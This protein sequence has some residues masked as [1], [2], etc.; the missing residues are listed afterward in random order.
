MGQNYLR[1]GGG[2]EARKQN[3]EIE[4]TLESQKI[5]VIYFLNPYY[6]VTFDDLFVN[7]WGEVKGEIRDPLK[8]KP[9]VVFTLENPKSCLEARNKKED[10]DILTLFPDTLDILLWQQ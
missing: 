10:P 5:E 3:S 4:S 1:G 7:I 6:G 8:N 2:D 9:L